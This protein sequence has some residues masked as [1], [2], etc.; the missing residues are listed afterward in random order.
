[1]DGQGQEKS[2]KFHWTRW[3][4]AGGAGARGSCKNF[5]REECKQCPG[6]SCSALSSGRARMC[7]PAGNFLRFF[8]RAAGLYTRRVSFPLCKFA[9]NSKR[10]Q[11]HV[12]ST[13]D[14]ERPPEFTVSFVRAGQPPAALQRQLHPRKSAR[15]F[16][17]RAQSVLLNF[18]VPYRV[19]RTFTLL[20]LVPN[21]DTETEGCSNRR[22]LD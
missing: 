16:V 11:P 1:M 9:P 13:T 10:V 7:T 14:A 19:V 5:V 12:R 21:F 8:R 2:R 6:R 20:K 4:R 17:S 3:G 18:T 22:G 15:Q